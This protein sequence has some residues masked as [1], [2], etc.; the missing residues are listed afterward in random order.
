MQRSGGTKWILFC[1]ACLIA[2]CQQS[3][4]PEKVLRNTKHEPLFPFSFQVKDVEGK[5]V[6]THEM[7]GKVL[8]VDVWGTWCPPCRKEIPHFVALHHKYN[9][10]GLE[11]VGLNVE[12][13]EEREAIRLIKDTIKSSRIPYSCVLA[14][15]D[16]TGQIPDL[17][18][19]PTTLILDRQGR[20]RLKL[21]GYHSYDEL[22]SVVTQLLTE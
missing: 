5:K 14:P 1:A 19:F 16:V 11:I 8:I 13:V 12:R 6:S 10:Q 7:L 18:V 15:R 9:S 3:E 22:E 17:Q 20:V 4:P 21:E 2:G